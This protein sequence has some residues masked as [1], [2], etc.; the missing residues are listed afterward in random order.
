M[1]S[2]SQRLSLGGWDFGQMTTEENIMFSLQYIMEQRL[3]IYSRERIR[4]LKA[5]GIVE[6]FRGLAL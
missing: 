5:G 1:N 6:Q 3:G 2:S 4:S